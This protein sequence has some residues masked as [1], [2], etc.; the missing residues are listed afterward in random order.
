MEASISQWLS[1]HSSSPFFLWLHYLEPHAAYVPQREWFDQF[2]PDYRGERYEFTND[3]L[4]E[5]RNSHQLLKKRNLKYI[6]AC[7]DSEIRCADASIGRLLDY[8]QQSGLDRNTIIIITSDHGEE[9]QDHGSLGHDH[10]LFD[11]LLH[12]PLIV[13]A[14]TVLPENT[15]ITD[16]VQS[17]DVFASITDLLGL[18]TPSTVQGK[19]IFTPSNAHAANT[20]AF[21]Y[22]QRYFTGPESH[23]VSYV[24]PPWKLIVTIKGIDKKDFNHWSPDIEHHEFQLYNMETDQFEHNDVSSR[25]PD[26]VESLSGRICVMLERYRR[27]PVSMHYEPEAPVDAATKEKLKSLGYVP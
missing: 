1:S 4:L 13:R 5:Q 23:L 25:H 6:E 27:D 7:Y 22:A 12:V 24:E 18:R 14:P 20:N 3:M 26:I 19:T 10:T 8:L 16:V 2:L 11:E 17:V 21:S 9:F 15:V